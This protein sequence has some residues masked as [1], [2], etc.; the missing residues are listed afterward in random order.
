MTSETAQWNGPCRS[1]YNW[2]H[3]W[4][5]PFLHIEYGNSAKSVLSGGVAVSL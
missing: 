1:H 3:I 5:A 4:Q 2:T